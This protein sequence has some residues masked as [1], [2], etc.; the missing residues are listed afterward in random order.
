[1]PC[2]SYLILQWQCGKGWHTLC[3]LDA[4]KEKPGGWFTHG[5][6]GHF[7]E[8]HRG[9]VH[10]VGVLGRGRK[11]N[12]CNRW[13]LSFAQIADISARWLNRG[14][15][16]RIWCPALAFSCLQISLSTESNPGN[17]V[18]IGGGMFLFFGGLLAS[19]G[20]PG[21]SVPCSKFPLDWAKSQA[22]LP[23]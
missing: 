13:N 17:V 14:G 4:H 21:Y 18:F 6:C 19:K 16:E 11:R 5:L 2:W 9:P 1:M 23:I 3:P 8:I 12:T 22:W 10:F 20:V 15:R 7:I